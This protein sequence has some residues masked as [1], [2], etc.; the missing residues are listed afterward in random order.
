MKKKVE[1]K[2]VR[3]PSSPTPAAR[4]KA[5]PRRIRV[6]IITT[7]YTAHHKGTAILA[8]R[9]RV[10]SARTRSPSAPEIDFSL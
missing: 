2:P 8:D 5:R 4:P 6:E 3:R 9:S 10:R 1:N 7:L